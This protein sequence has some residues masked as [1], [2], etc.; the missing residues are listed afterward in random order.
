MSS[1]KYHSASDED[2]QKLTTP[3]LLSLRDQA[4]HRFICS[5]GKGHHCGDEVLRKDEQDFND[6][7]SALRKRIIAILNTREH[8]GTSAQRKEEA[9]E[10]RRTGQKR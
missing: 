10:R 5:C 8:V 6:A 2:L 9:M 4:Y 1:G 7:Q 3:H